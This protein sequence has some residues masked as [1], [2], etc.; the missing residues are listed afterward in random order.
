M[1][2]P[3]TLTLEEIARRLNSAGVLWAVFARAA[4]SVYGVTRPVTDVDILVPVREGE[5]VASLFP[6]AEV[7]RDARGAVVGLELPGC[8]IL[9]GLIWQSADLFQNLDLDAPMAG[10]LTRH[11]IAGVL[12]PVIPPEDNILLKALWGRGQQWPRLHDLGVQSLMVA[13]RVAW[14]KFVEVFEIGAEC[15]TSVRFVASVFRGN[16]LPRVAETQLDAFVL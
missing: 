14:R 8:D 4:A 12:V 15:S 6:E 5:R 3:Q 11:E 16:R 10:R 2:Q 13:D 7:E 1:V 9:A